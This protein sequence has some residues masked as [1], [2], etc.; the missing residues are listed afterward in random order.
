MKR[1]SISISDD[2]FDRV[3]EFTAATFGSSSK[4]RRSGIIDSL[5]RKGLEIAD[6]QEEQD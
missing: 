5:I 1:L 3:E 4:G 6:E 2:T